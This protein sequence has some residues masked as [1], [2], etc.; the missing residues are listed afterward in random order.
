MHTIERE[1]V[2][3]KIPTY[4]SQ[5]GK[6]LTSNVCGEPVII[7]AFETSAVQPG[8]TCSSNSYYPD[9]TGHNNATRHRVYL[10]RN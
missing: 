9:H 1:N 10:K 6:V 4:I 7:A 3:S 8:I 5:L 2:T